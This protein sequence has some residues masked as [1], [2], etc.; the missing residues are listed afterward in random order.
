[1]NPTEPAEQTGTPYAT[2]HGE[3]ARL[4]DAGILA[5]RTAGR[6]GLLSA[7]PESPLASP[8]R[9]ILAVTT[10]P[11]VFPTQE[12]KTI[13]GIPKRIF[14]GDPVASDRAVGREVAVTVTPLTAG[15]LA[16]VEALE[17]VQSRRARRG[18]KSDN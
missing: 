15:Q 11:A 17:G 9:E 6:T 2:A 12:M 1:M 16:A 5:E 8:L 18:R 3:V 4:L 13:P 7:N 10:G 14:A